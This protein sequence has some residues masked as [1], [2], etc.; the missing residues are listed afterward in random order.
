MQDMMLD[1][2]CTMPHGVRR[3]TPVCEPSGCRE[4]MPFRILSLRMAVYLPSMGRSQPVSPRVPGVGDPCVCRRCTTA[5]VKTFSSSGPT[6]ALRVASRSYRVVRIVMISGDPF[7]V[8]ARGRRAK[9][10]PHWPSGCG[11]SLVSASSTV[12]TGVCETWAAGSGAYS[13]VPG[14]HV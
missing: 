9:L 5:A 13:G 1:M 2:R 12:S 4:C 3:Q 10:L 14:V 6:S 11:P 7:T 8:S